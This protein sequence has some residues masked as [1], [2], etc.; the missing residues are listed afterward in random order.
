MRKPTRSRAGRLAVRGR[1]GLDLPEHL[2]TFDKARLVNN[3]GRS[4]AETLPAVLQIRSDMFK[5]K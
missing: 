1:D 3:L 2:S 5:P 4:E